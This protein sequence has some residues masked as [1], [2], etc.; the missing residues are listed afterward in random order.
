MGKFA[1]NGDRRKKK[2]KKSYQ[3]I[4]KSGTFSSKDE[5]NR[6][7]WSSVRYRT[8]MVNVNIIVTQA[9]RATLSEKVLMALAVRIPYNNWHLY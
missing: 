2:Y 8:F 1:R 7:D 6:G 4:A 5:E 9:P 3:G